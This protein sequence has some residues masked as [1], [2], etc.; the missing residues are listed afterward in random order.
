MADNSILLAVRSGGYN[1]SRGSSNIQG[2]VTVD[3][4]DISSINVHQSKQRVT[5]GAS[6]IWGHVCEK[7]KPL[8]LAVV[9]AYVYNVGVGGFILG[10]GLSSLLPRFGFACDMVEDFEIVLASGETSTRTTTATATFGW[11]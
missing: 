5:I 7:L 3:L 11:H 1:P 6:A 9:G 10:R 2:G 8:R 4:R